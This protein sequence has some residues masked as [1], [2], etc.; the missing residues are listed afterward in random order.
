MERAGLR[1]K[2]LTRE[3]KQRRRN[4]QLK[5]SENRQWKQ[6]HPHQREKMMIVPKKMKLAQ[7]KRSEEVQVMQLIIYREKSV[8]RS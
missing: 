6:C 8:Q 7:R 2:I 3:I 1:L 4:R 5:K